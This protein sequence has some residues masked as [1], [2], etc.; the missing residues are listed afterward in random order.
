[1]G[2]SQCGLQRRR[3]GQ[4]LRELYVYRRQGV[5]VGSALLQYGQRLLQEGR[6]GTRHTLLQPRLAP[7]A[8]RR[9]YSSQPGV[10]RAVDTRYYR[11][12]SRV[13]PLRVVAHRAQHDE[14]QCVD[15]ALVS[16]ADYGSRSYAYVSLGAASACPQGWILH[17]GYLWRVVHH[18][19]SLRHQLAQRDG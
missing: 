12:D 15:R 5:G 18:N 11:G 3:V 6:G 1:M 8:R 10:C 17:D 19:D 13:L 4:G 2:C 14:W 9:G 7:C 16:G